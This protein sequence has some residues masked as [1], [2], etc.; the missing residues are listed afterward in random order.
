MTKKIFDIFAIF[1]N[2]LFNNQ[3][4]KS[5]AFDVEFKHFFEKNDCMNNVVNVVRIEFISKICNEKNMN[6]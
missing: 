1:V 5:F 3:F 4:V 2:H 6:M